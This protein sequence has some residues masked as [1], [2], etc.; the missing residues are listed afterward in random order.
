MTPHR[1]VSVRLS[2]DPAKSAFLVNGE[3]IL[4]LIRYL[5]AVPVGLLVLAACGVPGTTQS[6]IQP[7][8]DPLATL[9][10]S[11]LVTPQAGQGVVVGS[12]IDQ[13]TSQAAVKT[14][15]YLEPSL[16]HDAPLILYGPLNG[17]P[18]ANSTDTG[19]FVFENVPPGEYILV[20]YS[21]VDILYA[22]QP[23]ETALLV[24]V[25]AGQVTDLGRVVT[26][27]P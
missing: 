10:P 18:T 23:D 7:P 5:L 12:L 1:H 11:P 25:Q 4:R 8:A 26:D 17:Q 19:G 9:I 21:P 2:R 22:R 3:S 27:V 14:I 6:P 24:Q 13:R 20:L 16:N 15:L